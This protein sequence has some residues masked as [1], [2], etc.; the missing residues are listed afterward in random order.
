M[1]KLPAEIEISR[2]LVRLVQGRWWLIPGLI[3]LNVLAFLSEG[4]GIYLL[5][6]LLK[7]LLRQEGV[8]VGMGGVENNDLFA[9]LDAFTAYFAGPYQVVTILGLIIFFIFMRGVL[10]VASRAA[11]AYVG[12]QLGF[13]VRRDMLRRML[14]APQSFIDAQPP[15]RM[16]NILTVE[17]NRLTEGMNF[18]AGIVTHGVAVVTFFVMMLF[19]SVKLTLVVGT[20]MLAILALVYLVTTR[21]RRIGNR[22]TKDNTSLSARIAETLAGLRTIVLFNR[23]REEQ[24]RFDGASRRVWMQKFKLGVMQAVPSPMIMLLS[25][26]FIGV[27]IVSSGGETLVPLIVFLILMQRM[28]PHASRLMQH[29]VNILG[30]AG[31]LDLVDKFMQDEAATPLSSGPTPAPAPRHAIRIENVRYRYLRGDADAVAGLTLDIPV[32]KTTALVGHSGSGKSTVLSLV[33]RHFDPDEGAVLLDGTSLKEFDLRSWRARIATVP[34]DVFLFDESIRAN[35]AFGRAGASDAEIAEAIRIAGAEDFIAQLPDGLDTRLGDRGSQFS[36]GQRQ[37]IALARAIIANPDLLILDE[38]TNAL[39]NL[40]ARLVQDAIQK[41][42]AGRTVLV[43]AHRLAPVRNADHVV[44]L[45]GGRVVEQGSPAE[46]LKVSGAFARL[47]AA[48][49]AAA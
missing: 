20:G 28:Q 4:F 11:F 45:D 42:S 39:D 13:L 24:A 31:P 29:R 6:P 1:F 17:A 7:T 49:S 38:A 2:R 37:R 19:I 41:V 12:G 3:L 9:A 5:M 40:S 36:G 21:A 8:D 43:V 26:V 30:L 48:E 32:G 46:L 34:Q 16:L 15:G 10:W 25:A 47:V 22:L 14:A 18:F 35:I 23:D 44:V 27:L 33:C